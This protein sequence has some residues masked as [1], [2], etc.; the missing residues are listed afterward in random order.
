MSSA[1][2]LVA[3]RDKYKNALEYI[4]LGRAVNP[5]GYA[6]MIVRNEGTWEF[7]RPDRKTK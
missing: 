3:E 2:E 6:L 7:H 1:K 4:A 5:Q